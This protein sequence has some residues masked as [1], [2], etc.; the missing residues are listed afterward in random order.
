MV[1]T[2]AWKKRSVCVYSSEPFAGAA[3][4]NLVSDSEPEDSGVD[5]GADDAGRAWIDG[6]VSPDAV[7][8]HPQDESGD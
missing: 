4:T 3:G 5:C 8:S 7:A 2:T 1:E 6:C